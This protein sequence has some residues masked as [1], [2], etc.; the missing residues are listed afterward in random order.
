MVQ[1]ITLNNIIASADSS[2]LSHYSS[3]H[4]TTLHPQIPLPYPGTSGLALASALNQAEQ[5]NVQVVGLAVGFD[6]TH[7]PA[8]YQHWAAA[9]LP[10]TLPDALQAL[11]AAEEAGGAGSSA[12]AAADEDWS[13]LMPVMA[14]AASSVQEVLSQQ[15]SVFGDLVQQL[16]RHKE[17]KLIHAEPDDMSV[18]VCF[19]IDVTG[20]MSGWIEACKAQ[21]T[22]ICDGLLP[23]ISKK[24]PDVEVK[25]RWSLVAYRDQGDTDQLQELDF[26]EDP[27]ELIAKVGLD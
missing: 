12:A 27:K 10:A 19:C 16:S 13:V 22:T 2:S 3:P 23:K 8:C 24:C 20:S 9:A 25:V 14:G 15:R 7:V 11:Y 21:I 4:L 26:T 5:D 1:N 17:A 18:D 6:R